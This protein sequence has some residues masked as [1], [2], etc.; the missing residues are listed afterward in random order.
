MKVHHDQ[1]MA[2]VT[3]LRIARCGPDI[4]VFKDDRVR[5]AA[6]HMEEEMSATYQ[7]PFLAGVC[8][9]VLGLVTGAQPSFAGPHGG[10]GGMGGGMGM[11]AGGMGFGGASASHF[12]T[13]G[14]LNTNGPNA[15]DRDRGLDRAE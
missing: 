10:G 5:R 8:V 13:H 6:T 11:G 12:D 3:S 2:F 15:V 9:L 4:A 14:S 1:L 7:K